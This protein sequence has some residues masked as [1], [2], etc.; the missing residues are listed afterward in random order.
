[1]RVVVSAPALAAD[2]ARR[3]G[4]VLEMI[5]FQHTVF[6]LPFAFTAAILAADGIPPVRTVGWILA[7]CVTA[8]TAAMC[9]N[10]LADSSFDALNP[11][12]AT[13]ALPA[14]LMSRRFVAAFTLVNVVLFVLSAAMLNRMTLYLSPVA[15]LVILGY[16][17][18][19]RFTAYSHF[20]LG[21]ALA[22]APIGAWIAVTGQIAATPLMLGLAVLLWTAGFDLIYS[23]QDADFDRDT[24]LHSIPA[25][26]GVA[27]ALCI[28]R[29]LHVATVF[30]LAYAGVLAG[31]SWLYGI[32]VVVVA[33]LLLAQHLIVNPRDL[34]RI[35]LAFFTI[36][37]WVGVAVFIFTAIDL[38]LR[39]WGL[40]AR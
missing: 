15:L 33:I 16:S 37:S 23:C 28:A 18:T 7:A 40:D 30:A 2:L 11:R 4:I 34:S 27:A 32:G 25:R 8:R 38:Y 31:C 9:F 17:L 35:P 12:T 13:R 20:V 21:L 19:K 3:T 10:R 26:H 14:G 36:N 22:I 24:G 1:M 6:A 29:V 5:K 39:N